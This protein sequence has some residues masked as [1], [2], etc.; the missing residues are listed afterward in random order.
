QLVEKL[1]Y[2][3]IS[4]ITLNITGSERHEGLRACVSQTGMDRLGELEA[5]LKAFNKDHAK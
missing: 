3:G 4:A 5:R 2:Y 1:M